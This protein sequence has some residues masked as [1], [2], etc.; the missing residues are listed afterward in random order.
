[1]GTK[2]KITEELAEPKEM[3]AMME[4][5]AMMGTPAMMELAAMMG[6]PAASRT[7]PLRNQKGKTP[8]LP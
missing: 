3:P 8:D 1:M 4:L 6:T 2:T 5:A 7:A